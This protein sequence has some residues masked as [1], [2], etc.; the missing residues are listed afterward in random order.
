MQKNH[1]LAAKRP[2][3]SASSVDPARRKLE[4]LELGEFLEKF[5]PSIAILSGDAKGV[6]FPLHQRRTLLG[7]GPGVDLA[8]SEPSLARQHAVVEFRD[9]GFCIETLGS[10]PPLWLNGIEAAAAPL[11]DGTR[12]RLGRQ[13]LQFTLSERS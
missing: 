9:G 6:E 2:R 8:L 10:H 7:R 13:R 1:K 4:I 11:E 12:I 3:A 5:E